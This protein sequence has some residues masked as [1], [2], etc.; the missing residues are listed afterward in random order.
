MLTHSFSKPSPPPRVVIFGG[1]FLAAELARTLESAEIPSRLLRSAEVDLT[2]ASAADALSAILQPDDCVV[3]PAA[4]TP[5]KGR[6]VATLMKNLRMGES[7]CAALGRSGVAHFVYI[8]S[9]SVYDA[10]FSSL[11]NEEST[12]EPSDLYSLMHVA[13]E[14][15]L[16]QVCRQ[17][18]I[19]FA[20]VRPVA[21]YGPGD[22]HNSYGPNRFVRAALEQGK[23]TLF[24]GGEETRHH[25]FVSDVAEILR[26]CLVHRSTGVI[27]TATGNAISFRALADRIVEAAGHPVVVECLPRAS[28]ITHRQFDPTALIK[29][30]P[31]FHAMPLTDGLVRT[32]AGMASS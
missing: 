5:E 18:K 27:N 19:P 9:D 12:T 30:F 29:S 7:V 23:I 1:G 8:S 28:P 26:L 20:V 13:R 32:V 16:D 2:H 4:L 15:M 10:R 31:T 6:D 24:G 22:T 21:V 25:V 17:R 3:M 14:R 11:L